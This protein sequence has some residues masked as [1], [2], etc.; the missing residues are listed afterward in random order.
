MAIKPDGSKDFRAL[1]CLMTLLGLVVAINYV[2]RLFEGEMAIHPTNA[3]Y[4]IT[5]PQSKREQQTA[6]FGILQNDAQMAR[7]PSPPSPNGQDTG[8][9]N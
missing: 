6:I 5:A 9:I 2:I 1:S 4:S 8:S 3:W 7:Y